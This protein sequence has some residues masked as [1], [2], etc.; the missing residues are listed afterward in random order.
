[1]EVIDVQVHLNAVGHQAGLA[2]MDALGIDG[3]VIDQWPRTLVHLPNGAVRCNYDFAIEAIRQ[4]PARFALLARPD[5]RDSDLVQLMADLRRLPGCVAIRVDQPPAA[6]LRDGAYDLLFAT[7]ARLGFPT[8]VIVPGRVADI[9]PL[10]RRHD[11]LQF[12]ID[13]AGMPLEWRPADPRRFE[14]LDALLKLA[15][16]P[17]VA[18]KWGH[19]TKLSQHPFPF[20]DVIDQLARTVDSFGRERVL[21]E[22]DFTFGSGYETWGESLF[23]IRSAE[24]FSDD[25]KAWILGRA[26]R[27]ALRW[28]RPDDRVDAVLVGEQDWDAFHQLLARTGRLV[29]HRVRV[30]K[31]AAGAS[32]EPQ[33]RM[34][35]TVALP[36]IS[37]APLAEAV[38]AAI[39]GRWYPARSP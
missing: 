21:W 20:P 8:C 10:I 31:V 1:M 11:S 15:R 26:A 19:V 5:P 23:S 30:E 6:A 39:S 32:V 12:I 7:A 24:R 34:V 14:P 35:G 25:D 28:D 27:R 18:V 16:Y 3:L 33:G 13:H 36:G 38:A 29:S 4:Y 37:A 2:A 22:S 17:N 9:E